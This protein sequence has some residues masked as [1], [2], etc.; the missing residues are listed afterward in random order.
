MR[1]DIGSEERYKQKLL[2]KAEIISESA[3]RTWGGPQFP[4]RGFSCTADMNN[5]TAY[6]TTN[7]RRLGFASGKQREEQALYQANI[8]GKDVNSGYLRDSSAY[9]MDEILL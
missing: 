9:Q 8:R 3:N 6:A 5:R 2:I 7:G 1:L 4:Q